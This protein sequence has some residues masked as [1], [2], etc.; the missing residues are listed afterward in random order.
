MLQ[1]KRARRGMVTASHHLA[2]ESGLAVLR[3]GGNAIEAM[4]AVAA[5][6]SVVYPHMNGLGGDGFWL[7]H[8]PGEAAPLAIAG[9]GAAAGQATPELYRAAGHE[10]IPSRGP[11]AANTVAGTVS[12]WQAALEVSAQWGGRLPLARLLEDAVTYARDGYPVTQS[13]ALN[14]AADKAELESVPGWAAIFLDD[15]A[16]PQVGALFKQPALAE[17]FQALAERGLDDFYRGA[18][19]KRIA[20]ELSR[21]GSPLAEADFAAHQ[22]RRPAP[23]EAR[24]SCGR[25]FNHP[26]PTQGLAALL[27]LGIFDRLGCTAADGFDHIHG[28]VEA[29]KKAIL[30]RR[31]HVTDPAHMTVD[32][33]AL[34]DPDSL[35]QLAAEIDRS[36]AAP[37]PDPA[38]PGDTVWLGAVDGEGRAVSFIHS[39]YWE[40]GSALC[41][42]ETGI[43][44]QNRGSSFSLSPE[45]QNHLQPGRLPFHT[46]NPA[47]A[48]LDDGRVMVYGAMGGEG[49]PQTQAAVFTRHV[50]FGQELQAAVTAPRWVLARTWGDPRHDLRLEDRVPVELVESLRAAGHQVTLVEPFDEVMGHAGAIVLHPDGLMEGANDPRCDGLVAAF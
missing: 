20:A 9:V 45:Q 1:T 36:K 19:A 7:I 8:T 43:Q 38:L 35:A 40:F 29:T 31:R 3:E 46:N 11:L 14:V 41:L 30:Q 12:S 22:A 49:Q 28:L 4:V 37:W 34:L 5:T 48:L 39:I 23:L 15:G 21:V 33:Q 50:L 24:L 17:S 42:E 16:V 26:P 18:L 6:I 2:A 32:P 44:W 47:M 10:T 13:Q 27:T 25:V